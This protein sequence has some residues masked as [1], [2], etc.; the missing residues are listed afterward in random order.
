VGTIWDE[1]TRHARPWLAEYSWRGLGA[2]LVLVLGLLFATA[3]H[4]LLRIALRGTFSRKAYFKIDL[5]WLGLVVATLSLM[6]A[7]LGLAAPV[8]G[9]IVTVGLGLGVVA[10]SFAGLRV[11]GSQPFRVGDEIEIKG[12]DVTGMV[13]ETSLSETILRTRDN[14]NVIIPNRRLLDR[15]V[16]NHTSSRGGK[17]LRFQFALDPRPGIE[18]IEGQIGAIIGTVEGIESGY[19]EIR[20]TLIEPDSVT[21]IVQFSAPP[22][23]ATRAAS[24]F[25]KKS[26]IE[27]DNAG[28]AIRSLGALAKP[29]DREVL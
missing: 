2:V 1:L 27:F 4:R 11:I 19:R 3:V 23:L 8:V 10:D 29:L 17:V 6:L 28:V 18:K 15:L 13:I 26:K 7:V 22:H 25:L 5:V 20:V 21:L 24:E 16:I 9:F 14:T 12:E